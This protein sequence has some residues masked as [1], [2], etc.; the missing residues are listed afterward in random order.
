M[1][2]VAITMRQHASLNERAMRR[3]P[4]TMEEYLSGRMIA[5]SRIAFRRLMGLLECVAAGEEDVAMDIR[6]T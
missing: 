3:Q 6:N 1:G 4:L 2:E 5:E